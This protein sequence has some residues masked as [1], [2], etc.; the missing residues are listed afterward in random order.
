MLEAMKQVLAAD[1]LADRRVDLSSTRA[2][3]TMRVK[4]AM[5]ITFASISPFLSRVQKR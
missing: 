5:K 1:R 3:L 2:K 4:P